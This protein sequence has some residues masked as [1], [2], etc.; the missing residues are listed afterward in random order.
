MYWLTPTTDIVGL[1]QTVTFS[2]I[3]EALVTGG[4]AIIQ[5]IQESK[6]KKK[7]KKSC[8]NYYNLR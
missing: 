2:D 3:D 6:C 8:E 1:L 7:E 4:T 5:I